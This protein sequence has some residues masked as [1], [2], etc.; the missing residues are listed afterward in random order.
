MDTPTF[1]TAAIAAPHR[2]AA[3]S[4]RNVLA[5]GGNAIEAM[6]A[7][8]ATI[9]VVYPHMNGIG[10]DGFWLVREPGGRVRGIEACGP[11]GARASIAR[12]RALGYDEIPFRGPEA[13]A[14][15]AGTVGGWALALDY[16]TSL[17]GRLELSDLLGDAVR[18]ARD[19][20]EVSASELRTEP[21]QR[22]ALWQAPNFAAT[23]GFDGKPADAVAVRRNAK[24][25]D[26]LSHLAFAGLE[27]LYRGDVG[28]EIGAD[29]ERLGMPVTRAD[30]E[31]YRAVVREPLEARLQGGVSLYNM[32]P[33][34]QGIASLL[35]LGIHER[36]GIEAREGV[37]RHHGLIE[38]TKRAFRIRDA[39][40]TDFREL[41][42][43]PRDFLTPEGFAR[44]AAAIDMRRAAPYPAPATTGDTVWMGAID[45]AGLA[46]SFIQSIYWEWGSGC[47]L[48][49]TGILLQNRGASFSLDPAAVNPLEPGRRP[50]H[51]LNPALAAYDDGR[52]IAYGAMGG[53]G[54]PQFQAQIFTRY[55]DL[56]EGV[57][58]AIDAPR[59]LLGRTWGSS[60]T[61]LKLEDGFDPE[62]VE[63]LARLGHEVETVPARYSDGLGHAGM[64]VKHRR[65]GRVE[66]MHDPRSDGG[67]EGL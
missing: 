15:V 1:S 43:D 11:A 25:A 40:V 26:T 24:L 13:A 9:A 67:A 22:D 12:Y 5:A 30:Y 61:S 65:D 44:E 64:L 20:V 46:V 19:G 33:P 47:V 4:G 3:E 51:T 59:W 42:R 66:A 56:G 27:D 53:D 45:A 48:P 8:A 34:T 35:L 23:F 31:A 18:F 29:L 62:I 32:P 63:G 36:L 49:A 38:A 39:V 41:R 28:R 10:G 52:V 60:S 16:A 54:Q 57:G 37:R 17:G 14:T 21:N 6:V 50:F 7:M 58:R 55:A 2:L